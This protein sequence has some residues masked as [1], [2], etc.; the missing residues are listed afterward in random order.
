V[1]A[2]DTV[3]RFGGDELVILAV[4]I[5]HEQDA[6]VS[7][8]K[9]LR[10]LRLPLRAGGQS[11]MSRQASASRYTGDAWLPKHCCRTRLGHVQAK[12]LGRN[13]F[14]YYRSD[15]QFKRHPKT[16]ARKRA[17]HAV[18]SRA[19]QLHYQRS[20][21]SKQGSWPARGAVTL[22]TPV[23]WATSSDQFMGIAEDQDDRPDRQLGAA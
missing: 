15:L 21:L 16:N 11:C 13:S 19:L 1:R 14:Q 20:S 12:H 10:A 17:S 3:S 22:A 6:A 4:R 7:A 8:D 23:V 5:G 2:S 18:D 9:I